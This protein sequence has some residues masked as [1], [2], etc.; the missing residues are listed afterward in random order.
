MSIVCGL[1]LVISSI[2]TRILNGP[3]YC[4]RHFY[5]QYHF[6]NITLP[7]YS[8]LPRPKRQMIVMDVGEE[9]S[10]IDSQGNIDVRKMYKWGNKVWFMIS[11]HD[12]MKD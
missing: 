11:R 9:E 5:W 3:W 1:V 4:I 6:T 2:L 10:N 7:S 12:F 8:N